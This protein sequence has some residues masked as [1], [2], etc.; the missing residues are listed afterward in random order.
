[1]PQA[2]QLALVFL[3]GISFGMLLFLLAAGL[4]LML[5][6]MNIVNLAHG[7]FYMLAGFIGI[8]VAIKTG[9][10]LLGAVAGMF[11]IGFIGLVMERFFLRRLPGHIE[12]ML[13]TLGC[14]Y[15]IY[16]LS[17]VAWGSNPQYLPPPEVLTGS[18]PIGDLQYPIY[19]LAIIGFGAIIAFGLWLFL[20]KTRFGAII[21]AGADDK[22]MVEGIGIDIKLVFTMVFTL[23]A[24]L[25]GLS[26]VLATPVL[27]ANLTLDW[28]VLTLAFVVIVVGGLRTLKGALIGSLLI[29]IVDS[30]GIFFFPEL[31]MFL[32]FG[33]TALILA[34]RPKGL[35]GYG[36]L[37]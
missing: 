25:A 13:F 8:A 29:G 14:V 16:D 2:D 33:V 21:R 30:V 17:R 9:N 1:V 36:G 24:L 11:A 23:A 18:V 27:T 22:E 31:A 26:G 4:V 5:G 28:Q 3:N 37:R 20:E 7:S 34:F 6:I 15:I 12:Q 10:F 35:I 32:M 19:R